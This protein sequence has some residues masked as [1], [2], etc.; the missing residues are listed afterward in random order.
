MRGVK[1]RSSFK[2]TGDHICHLI[3]VAGDVDGNEGR[4]LG[5]VEAQTK[6]SEEV[7]RHDGFGVTHF[8]APRN[9]RGVVAERRD[10]FVGEVDPAVFQ[11]QKT[12]EHPSEFQVV[13]GDGAGRVGG[14]DKCVLDVHRPRDLPQ[15]RRNG[16]G[17]TA[18]HTASPQLTRIGIGDNRRRLFDE[19]EDGSGMGR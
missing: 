13:D 17:A 5:S 14:S 16:K 3:V 4:R 11:S 18:P 19:L 12:E 9:R 6:I 8:V 15:E 7:A 10:V 1:I 2:C